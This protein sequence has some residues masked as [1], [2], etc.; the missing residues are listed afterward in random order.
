MRLRNLLPSLILPILFLCSSIPGFTQNS[1]NPKPSTSEFPYWIEMMQQPEV[2]FYTVK[3]AFD[4]YWKDRPIT[5]SSGW[6]QYKRWEYKTQLRIKKDGTRPDPSQNF[7]AYTKYFSQHT[8]NKEGNG[9]WISLGPSQV[10]NGSN[11]LGRLNA[12]AFH[13]VNSQMLYVGAP[14][15]GLWRTTDGGQSWNSNTDDLPTLGVSSIVVDP[16]NPDILYM[17]TGDRDAGDAAGIGV[18]KSTDGGN[19]WSLSNTGMGTVVVGKLLIHPLNSSVLF[20]AASNGL[21]KSTD[22]GSNWTQ[23]SSAGNFKDLVFKPG[24]PNVLYATQGGVFYKSV[25]GG[26]SFYVTGQGLTGGARGVIGVSPANPELVYFLLCNSES[27]KAIFRSSDAGESFTERSNSPNIMSWGCDGGNGGQAWY[28]LDIAVDP[29]NPDIIFAGGVNIFRS[30]NGGTDWEIVAHWYGGC[31]VDDVHA[32]LHVL[33][34]SPVDGRLYAGND[35]GIY[36]TENGGEDWQMISQGL[37]IGQVYKIGQSATSAGL[38]MNGYQDNGTSCFDGTTWRNVMGG[39]GM[40]CAIDKT[41]VLYKYGTVY[42]G[43][44]DRIYNF[45]NQGNIA[46]NGTNGITEEGA[47]VTPF[48]L[49]ETD[50]NTMFI[51]YKNVWRSNNVKAFNVNSVTW[52]KISSFNGSNGRVLEQSPA[53][54]DILYVVK[55]N[56]KIYRTDNAND[57]NPQWVDLSNG[58][59]A[60]GTPTD[61]E[62]HPLNPAIVYMTGNNKVYKSINYGQ[63]WTDISA[64]LPDVSYNTVIYCAGSQEGLYVGSD[65][66]VFYKDASMTD[67]ISFSNGLPATAEITELDIYYDQANPANNKIKAATYGRGLWE[68]NLFESQPVAALT[69]DYTQMPAGCGINFTDLSMGFPTSWKWEF[70]GG[71]PSQSTQQNP[72]NI[73][74]A[75]TG[76]FDVSLIVSNSQGSDTLILPG[77]ITISGAILPQPGFTASDSIFCSG[78]AVVTFSD[79]STYCPT[80]WLWTFDPPTV[81]FLNGTTANMQSCTVQFN[82]DG[83]YTV[84]L[85]VGNVNGSIPYTRNS[86]IVVG[87]L[88]LPFYDNFES[89]K[90][91]TKAWEITN[92]NND[93]TWEVVSTGGN[94]PG[95]KSARVY[96]FGTNSYGRRDRLITPPLNLSGLEEVSLYFKHA[97]AQYQTDYTDSLIIYASDNCGTSWTRLFSGGDDGTGSFATHA[98]QI[99]SFVPSAN[100]DWCGGPYGSSCLAVDLGDFAGKKNVKIAFETVSGLSNNIYIDDVWIDSPEG[101][102]EPVS[103]SGFALYPN[104]GTGLFRLES[105]L[106]QQIQSVTV[107]S[108][109]GQV[110]HQYGSRYVQKGET[111]E[112]RLEGQAPGVYYLQVQT[113]GK[114]VSKKIM[115]Q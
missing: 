102:A 89:G 103:E 78:P 26:N 37:T 17:G 90:L 24:D 106:N 60:I 81:S 56:E 4:D 85:T 16:Q 50:P 32:D 80:T 49:H 15:G 40:E 20:A 31:D 5:R 115:L 101:I 39:D 84:T 59:S 108:A 79:T 12:I 83:A 98:P 3:Q 23:V 53:N 54:P 77:Y 14:S 44:I 46:S 30:Q 92:P 86:F 69:S 58:I 43:S 35:G 28:D 112:I 2:N 68:S 22:A 45:S 38:T 74:Y 8:K 1:L 99:F 76:S 94:G 111:I 61:L 113:E 109:Y 57:A 41:N 75:A 10:P 82:S 21:Y 27:F 93:K 6:K 91:A 97:Y 100:T 11:G 47:W 63:S 110:L 70:P 62:C 18:M 29:L 33:E 51:G 7:K 87:G 64:S 96:I 42:Y 25:N 34:Y 73:L 67:W 9:N 72:Q 66:G 19:T 105:K 71:T 95:I 48:I 107:F 104:P 65:I 114:M 36:F 52:T 13:P 88:S 55:E